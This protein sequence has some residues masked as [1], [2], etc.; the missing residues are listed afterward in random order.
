MWMSSKSNSFSAMTSSDSSPTLS[1]SSNVDRTV[2]I[3]RHR[4]RW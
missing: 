1:A 2:V 3:R 4:P